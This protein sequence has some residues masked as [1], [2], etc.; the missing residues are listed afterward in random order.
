MHISVILASS[1]RQCTS[2]YVRRDASPRTPNMYRDCSGR[3][4]AAPPNMG[5]GWRTAN[6]FASV[7]Q[8]GMDVLTD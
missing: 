6:G 2:T 4:K 5:A 1:M 7:L 3:A 8:R